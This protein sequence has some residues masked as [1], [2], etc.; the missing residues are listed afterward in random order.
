MKVRALNGDVAHVGDVVCIKLHRFHHLLIISINKPLI[1]G[2]LLED[3]KSFKI[4]PESVIE[5][6]SK[7]TKHLEMLT[8]E[9]ML[10]H[11]HEWI[12]LAGKVKV[13]HAPLV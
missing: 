9:E 4:V 10:T 1:R 8:V 6:I 13:K 7:E 11:E 3:L 12:R 5:C 2:V